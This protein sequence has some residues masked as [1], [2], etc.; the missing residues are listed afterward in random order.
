MVQSCSAQLYFRRSFLLK[1]AYT[2]HWTGWGPFSL[3]STRRH[4]FRSSLEV[5]FA[6]FPEWILDKLIQRVVLHELAWW[7][8]ANKGCDAPPCKN[9]ALRFSLL[10]ITTN[11]RL[12]WQLFLLAMN[13][14]KRP[15]PCMLES[16]NHQHY[17]RSSF[18][19]NEEEEPLPQEPPRRRQQRR[20]SMS[21]STAVTALLE[22]SLS[23]F[24]TEPAYRIR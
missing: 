11:E 12:I 1:K 13:H 16:S 2:F 22:E 6:R 24:D 8:Y 9:V 18:E 14:Q 23:M 4:H 3:H 17:S 7:L 20:S 15:L 19:K 10:V 5:V 21:A